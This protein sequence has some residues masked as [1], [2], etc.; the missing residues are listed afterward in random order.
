MD[1]S[2]M[3]TLRSAPLVSVL[4]RLDCC[5]K[6]EFLL[7]FL[8]DS[9]VHPRPRHGGVLIYVQCSQSKSMHQ[10]NCLDKMA[11]GMGRCYHVK[12]W[13]RGT[14]KTGSKG[15][16]ATPRSLHDPVDICTIFLDKLNC[17]KS[18]L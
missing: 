4:A 12:Q 10:I 3:Q 13:G 2:L 7:I 11:C 9:L 14:R 8:T 5:F 16:F 18:S 15:N 6:L 1:T 17:C